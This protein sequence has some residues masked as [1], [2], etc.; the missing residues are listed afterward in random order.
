MPAPTMPCSHVAT[1]KIQRL[2]QEARWCQLCGALSSLDEG[3]WIS[4]TLVQSMPP[5]R[6]LAFVAG[7]LSAYAAPVQGV[8]DWL[9]ELAGFDEAEE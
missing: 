6:K 1:L 5:P 4:P 3:R 7:Y 8:R 2:E 9:Y